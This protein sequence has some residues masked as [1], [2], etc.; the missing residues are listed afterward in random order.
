MF[1]FLKIMDLLKIF[2]MQEPVSK[3][4]LSRNNDLAI[5]KET[6][7]EKDELSKERETRIKELQDRV[8]ELEKQNGELEIKLKNDNA[9]YQ[10][11]M[12]E[13]DGFISKITEDSNEIV[14]ENETFRRKLRE[15][16]DL[17]QNH[18]STKEDMRSRLQKCETVINSI[19][20]KYNT[21]KAHSQTKLTEANSE[22][23][24]SILPVLLELFQA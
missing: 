14:K 7:R 15:L 12:Q 24:K 19:T 10:K 3:E 22:V 9:E 17:L 1:G 11:I 23:G 16:E 8:C 18:E 5:C 13:Y 21:L 4:L 2:R 6:I 20:H